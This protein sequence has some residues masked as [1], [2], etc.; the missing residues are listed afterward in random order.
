MVINT[1]LSMDLTA[2]IIASDLPRPMTMAIENQADVKRSTRIQRDPTQHRTWNHRPDGVLWDLWER[3][4]Q[5]RGIECKK[6]HSRQQR[7]TYHI[8]TRRDIASQGHD[9]NMKKC[10]TTKKDVERNFT[11]H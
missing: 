10:A 8:Q 11:T 1:T 7:Q 2:G 6:P 4:I 9:D 3:V 5:A